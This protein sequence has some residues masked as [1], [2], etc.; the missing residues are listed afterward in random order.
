MTPGQRLSH[1]HT[2][3]MKGATRLAIVRETRISTDTI[4]KLFKIV[5]RDKPPQALP[6]T[7]CVQAMQELMEAHT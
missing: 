7:V 4:E 3:A 6:H 2:M 1:A 5:G